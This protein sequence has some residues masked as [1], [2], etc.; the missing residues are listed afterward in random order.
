MS[1]ESIAKRCLEASQRTGIG[2]TAYILSEIYRASH[3][4]TL[5][6]GF[7]QMAADRVLLAI[8]KQ[9]F[10]VAGFGGLGLHP[11]LAKRMSKTA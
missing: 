6:P 4:K 5:A 7:R 9:E 10:K 3:E 8:V 1:L 2:Y 11:V